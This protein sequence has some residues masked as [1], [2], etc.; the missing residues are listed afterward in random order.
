MPK[1]V[2]ETPVMY[3]LYSHFGV[4]EDA[5]FRNWSEAKRTKDLNPARG[6]QAVNHLRNHLRELKSL[7]TTPGHEGMLILFYSPGFRWMLDDLARDVYSTTDTKEHFELAADVADEVYRLLQDPEHEKLAARLRFITAQDIKPLLERAS[8][9]QGDNFPLY[10]TGQTEGLRY[11]APKIV[12]A[13]ARLRLVGN[14]VP[15]FRLDSDVLF[16]SQNG[17]SVMDDLGLFKAIACARYAYQLRLEDPTVS[18]FLFSTS[19]DS[20]SIE[21]GRASGAGSFAKWSGAYAT[22]VF[23]ALIANSELY[24]DPEKRIHVRDKETEADLDTLVD[25]ELLS[26]Y[27]GMQG[28]AG[29]ERIGAHPRYGVIS[30]AL[31]CLSDGAIIDL[32]PFSNFKLNVMWID[33][34]LKFSLH[35]ALKHFTSGPTLDLRVPALSHARLD[36]V[37][38]VKARPQLWKPL[39]IYVFA[40]YLPTLLM[41]TIMDVWITPEGDHILKSRRADLEG[42]E[43]VSWE[44]AKERSSSGPLPRYMAK[45]LNAGKMTPGEEAALKDELERTA[46]ERIERVRQ[47]WA[48]LH[49]NGKRTFASYWAGDGNAV[50]KD[51]SRYFE[52]GNFSGKQ[53]QGI[54]PHRHLDDPLDSLGAVHGGVNTMVRSLI[55]DAVNYV[56]WTI[57]WPKYVQIFRATP[58]GEFKGDLSWR[59]PQD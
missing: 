25:P 1:L 20:E 46:V 43:A 11:D 4:F 27:Y 42:V 50:E 28:E 6:L 33:D 41:G 10:F 39:P 21:N 30:G 35:R 40:E 38:V 3:A 51:F 53:W 29:L 37:S 26:R 9:S 45:V 7:L 2:N 49:H 15:V 31:L 54:A 19:Y 36:R 8:T 55:T 12:E 24:F 23:P 13:I 32:P 34:H 59:L 56:R 5:D 17:A 18:T 52:G 44:K 14:G 16:R 22:R 47:A 58:Q 48:S 57:D